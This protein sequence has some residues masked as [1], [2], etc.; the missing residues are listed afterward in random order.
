MSEPV[1]SEPL[2]PPLPLLSEPAPVEELLSDA[3]PEDPPFPPEE[4]SSGSERLECFPERFD[5]FLPESPTAESRAV[6]TPR[7]GT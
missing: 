7:P 1:L 5:S 3:P 6:D 2:S 4:L